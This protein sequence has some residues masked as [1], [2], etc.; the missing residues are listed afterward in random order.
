[1]S[2]E[3]IWSY[4]IAGLASSGVS[5][6][7]V[8]IYLIKNPE[9]IEKWASLFH[10]LF[11]GI[12]KNS[13]RNYMATN[14]QYTIDD[15]RKKLNF[16]DKGMHYGLKIKWTEEDNIQTDL[17]DSKVVVMMR[18]Y[19]SQAINLAHIISVYVPESLMPT[20]RRYV[21]DD[22]MTGLDHT[23]SKYFLMDNSIAVNYYIDNFIDER[24][25]LLSE[26]MNKLDDMNNL[27]Y[28]S[29]VMI[30]ELEKLGSL[31]PRT[32]VGTERETLDLFDSL[33]SFYETTNEGKILSGEGIYNGDHLKMVVVPVGRPMLLEQ[34]GIEK[35]Y[36]FIED[37][38][39]E[40][41]HSFYLVYLASDKGYVD[42]LIQECRLKIYLNL[43][44]NE[45]YDGVFRGNKTKLGCA[46]LTA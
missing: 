29:R 18:P 43:I 10:K 13:A 23:I 8:I 22:L 28:L 27:G 38:F 31:Y 32:N 14:I 6:A 1:M 45:V 7:L 42:D 26:L 5:V 19:E 16:E 36:N 34:Y 25:N 17:D 46:L 39:S 21:D 24:D 4:I 15:K 37:H 40:G 35:H 3:N 2:L 33:Y 12:N 20:S 9:K 30:P 44:Y 11:A 41:I